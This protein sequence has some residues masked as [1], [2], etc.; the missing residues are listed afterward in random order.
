MIYLGHRDT[1]MERKREGETEETGAVF[2]LSLFT[3]SL[4]SLWLCGSVAKN[5]ETYE[6]K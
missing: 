4:F 3:L 6:Q 5:E 2:S 1:E